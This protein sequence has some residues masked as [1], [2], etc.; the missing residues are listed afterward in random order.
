MGGPGGGAGQ[1]GRN[2]CG[3]CCHVFVLN[4]ASILPRKVA[5]I[6]PRKVASI[7]P[8]CI[9][10]ASLPCKC[11]ISINRCCANKMSDSS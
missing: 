11:I 2:Y 7:L 5:S 10:A 3:H 1:L 4:I 8:C 6:L 9:E